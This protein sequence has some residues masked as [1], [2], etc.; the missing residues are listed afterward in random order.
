[1]RRITVIRGRIPWDTYPSVRTVFVVP[2]LQ[3]LGM[4]NLKQL[5]QVEPVEEPVG[6][7]A[8]LR[9]ASASKDTMTGHWEMMG[10]KVTTPF[11]TFTDTGF[12]EDLIAELERQDG[13]TR[14]L[15][16]RVPA[17]RSSWMNWVKRRS[18]RG[19]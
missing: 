16:I 11:K 2:N 6:Y 14:L 13:I 12:P 7:Y 15:A 19:I 10:L 3:K 1:M 18:Q 5:K 9:E 17:E 8:A 4:A